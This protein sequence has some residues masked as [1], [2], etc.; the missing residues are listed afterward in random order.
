MKR[1]RLIIPAL[2]IFLFAALPPLLVRAEPPIYFMVVNNTVSPFEDA[3]QPW[4]TSNRGTLIPHIVLTGESAGPNGLGIGSQWFPEERYFTLYNNST[5]LTFVVG[6]N[7]AFSGSDRYVAP[8]LR[9]SYNNEP[10]F[11]LPAELVCEV[12]GFNL[13][14]DHSTEWGTMVRITNTSSSDASFVRIFGNLLIKPH[15]DAY[16]ESLLPPAPS[17][18]ISAPLPSAAPPSPAAPSA[19]PLD[20]FDVSVY[21]SFDGAVNDATGPL[22]DFLERE[23]LP[24]LFFLSA[25]NLSQDPSAVRR[26]SARHQIGLLI[27]EPDVEMLSDAVRRGNALLRETAFVKTWLLRSG[28]VPPEHLGYRYWGYSHRFSEE[29]TARE[30]VNAITPL[31]EKTLEPVVLVFSLPHSDAAAEALQTL[32]PLMGRDNIWRVNPGEMPVR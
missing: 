4:P 23:G 20:Y 31:L 30:L 13:T 25:E 16:I 12:F 10:L 9:A 27:D 2:L 21:L 15:Y 22:L 11:F 1:L 6:Q 14:T 3:H 29:A 7:T 24:A 5:R 28:N 17:P 19:E 8:L 18:D 26:I 32:L